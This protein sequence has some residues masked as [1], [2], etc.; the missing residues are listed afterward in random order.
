MTNNDHYLVDLSD[1]SFH[2]FDQYIYIGKIAGTKSA[3]LSVTSLD[4]H[5]LS[6]YQMTPFKILTN[7]RKTAGTKC[8]LLVTAVAVGSGEA[9]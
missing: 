9:A 4:N 8:F 7:S 1:D 5:C 3:P 2:K 6:T